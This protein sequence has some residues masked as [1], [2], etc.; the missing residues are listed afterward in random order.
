MSNKNITRW[1]SIGIV[2]FVL[3]F[4]VFVITAAINII[5][6][7]E[8][9]DTT[10]GL[11]SW[12]NVGYQR[13]YY[14]TL[15]SIENNLGFIIKTP[16]VFDGIV[17]P[18]MPDSKLNDATLLGVDSNHDGIR[19]DVEIWINRTIEDKNLRLIFKQI[20][21]N[22]IFAMY[23]TAQGNQSAM[24]S[25]F[26][27][28]EALL[29]CAFE[30]NPLRINGTYEYLKETDNLQQKLKK[31]VWTEERKP[32]YKTRCEEG[33]RGQHYSIYWDSWK[34]CNSFIPGLE[35]KPYDKN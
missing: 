6:V 34:R 32:L 11:N 27:Y 33:N 22:E 14:K 16:K 20:A 13:F 17:E 4:F 31:L 12:M 28:Q 1:F 7:Y 9:F 30:F 26:V 2:T 10:C 3:V 21:R 29:D 35:G 19:D 18:S 24:K 25:S 5:T 23:V 8:V 15:Q